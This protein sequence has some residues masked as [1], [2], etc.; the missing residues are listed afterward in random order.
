MQGREWKRG[1]EEV[2]VRSAYLVL[3]LLLRA[4]RMSQKRGRQGSHSAQVPTTILPNDSDRLACIMTSSCIVTTN[5]GLLT[6]TLV[7][8]LLLVL[9]G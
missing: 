8:V 2:G 1:V 5:V 3:V 7:L 6:S 4:R 9:F